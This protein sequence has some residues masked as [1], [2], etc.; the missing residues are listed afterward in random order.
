MTGLGNDFQFEPEASTFTRFSTVLPWSEFLQHSPQI[1]SGY[2]KT[3]GSYLF[4]LTAQGNAIGPVSWKRWHLS[5][6]THY[7]CGRSAYSWPVPWLHPSLLIEPKTWRPLQNAL[8]FPHRLYIFQ[9][10]RITVEEEITQNIGLS[11]SSTRRVY[12]LN[13]H[14]FPNGANCKALIVSGFQACSRHPHGRELTDVRQQIVD[15]FAKPIME[16][17]VIFGNAFQSDTSNGWRRYQK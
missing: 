5:S 1:F 8:Q 3:S 7:Y 15:L 2:T 6:F 12:S 13:L 10:N 4:G 11:F 16:R 17:L 14:N 9:W